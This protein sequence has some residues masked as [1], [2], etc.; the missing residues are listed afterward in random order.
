MGVFKIKHILNILILVIATFLS[1]I[2]HEGFH[3]IV[4][5]IFKIQVDSLIIGSGKEIL[6]VKIKGIEIQLNMLPFGGHNNLYIPKEEYYNFKN[7][8]ILVS[9]AGAVGDLIFGI[10]SLYIL[11]FLNMSYYFKSFIIAFTIMSLGSV[12]FTAIRKPK[13]KNNDR[14]I[15][16]K[17]LDDSILEELE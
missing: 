10:I 7:K 15:I 1:I 12:Y 4:A 6:I 9:L 2:I 13:N 14:R 16:E 3:F 11:V 5:K 8:L 17:I